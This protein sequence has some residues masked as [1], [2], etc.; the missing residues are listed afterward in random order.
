MASAL[1]QERCACTNVSCPEK[2]AAEIPAGPV[3]SFEHDGEHTFQKLFRAR[4]IAAESAISSVRI[5]GSEQMLKRFT[6][7]SIER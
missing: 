7:R 2:S 3:S 5:V 4:R 1:E 6:E